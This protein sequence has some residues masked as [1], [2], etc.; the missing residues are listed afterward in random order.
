MTIYRTFYTGLFIQNIFFNI[1]KR[2]FMHY[3][4]GAFRCVC[5]FAK[6]RI[7]GL[8]NLANKLRIDHFVVKL[9][10]EINCDA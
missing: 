2:K 9:V 4:M 1:V 7:Y 6:A 3:C 10:W 5:S 8:G